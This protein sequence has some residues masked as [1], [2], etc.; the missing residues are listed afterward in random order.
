MGIFELTGL[1]RESCD[2]LHYKKYEKDFMYKQLDNILIT[3]NI[4][5]IKNNRW[6]I[7][8]IKCKNI[9]SFKNETIISVKNF[10]NKTL[11]KKIITYAIY[12]YIDTNGSN[13]IEHHIYDKTK[14]KNMYSSE[15]VLKSENQLFK[16]TR[17]GCLYTNKMEITE[18]YKY[19]TKNQRDYFYKKTDNISMMC[20]FDIY[21][22]LFLNE[23]KLIKKKTIY[24]LA[25]TQK[26]VSLFL[27]IATALSKIK[28]KDGPEKSKKNILINTNINILTTI[29]ISKIPE[30]IVQQFIKNINEYI[31]IKKN[32]NELISKYNI[33]IN[34]DL[35]IMIK[36]NDVNY[37]DINDINYI[38]NNEKMLIELCVNKVMNKYSECNLIEQI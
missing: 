23:T 21:K 3:S 38:S 9:Y 5:G 37:S 13:K 4:D 7:I 14:D 11:L 36:T 25:F 15:I 17:Y 18:Y 30:K 28:E 34:N 35:N 33:S 29:F 19:E 31:N 26:Y 20:P 10:Q 2:E 1:I 24:D 6:T 8:S 32:E 16:I 12:G 22:Y 27:E